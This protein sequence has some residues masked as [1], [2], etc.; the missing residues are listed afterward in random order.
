MPGA[1]TAGAAAIE[2]AYRDSAGR[3][4]ATLTRF[5]GDL[6]LAEEAVQEAYAIALE[7]WPADGIPPNPGG[8]IVTTARNKALDWARKAT[9]ACLAPVEVRPF[10]DEPG[11]TE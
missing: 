6:D 9:V 3:A 5:L 7:R 1:S 11:P 8:W 10:E 4:V 2:R